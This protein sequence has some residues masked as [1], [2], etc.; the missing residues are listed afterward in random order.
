MLRQRLV[1]GTAAAL[2]VVVLALAS[3]PATAAA[4]ARAAAGKPVLIEMRVPAGAAVWFD[5]VKATQ[6]GTYR[7]YLSPPLAPGHDYAYRVRVRWTDGNRQVEETKRVPVRAGDTV[8]LAFP[9]ARPSV[10]RSAYRA[11]DATEAPVYS[12]NP[13]GPAPLDNGGS[14]APGYPV[15]AYEVT[16]TSSRFSGPPLPPWENDGRT[17]QD[18][19]TPPYWGGGSR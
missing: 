1:S 19:R 10:R 9:G 8:T 15:R 13:S 18:D 14:Y 2:V 6:T 3:R 17:G 11:P 16:T 4:P 5:G 12:S 7:S